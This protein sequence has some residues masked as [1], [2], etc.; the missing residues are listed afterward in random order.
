MEYEFASLS[1]YPNLS[2]SASVSRRKA[3]ENKKS[4]SLIFS[5][6]IMIYSLFDTTPFQTITIAIH[7]DPVKNNCL[8]NILAMFPRHL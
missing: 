6:L 3:C 1:I 2:P 8:L 5:I 7:L 4:D